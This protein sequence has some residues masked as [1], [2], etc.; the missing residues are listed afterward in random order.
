MVLATIEEVTEV[1]S[2]AVF[3]CAVLDYANSTVG[4]VHC[5]FRA[6]T[7]KSSSV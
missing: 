1:A 4:T 3:L 5:S 2:I 6:S 7:S